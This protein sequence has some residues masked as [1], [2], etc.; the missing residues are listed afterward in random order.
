MYGAI[1]EKY[2]QLFSELYRA[3]SVLPKK[4]YDQMAEALMASHRRELTI[5][6]GH[7]ELETG[8]ALFEMKQKLRT[9]VPRKFLFYRNKVAKM[10]M[11]NCKKEFESYLSTFNLQESESDEDCTDLALVDTPCQSE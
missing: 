3:R 11:N 1:N 2:I 7:I 10:V 6:N 9:F 5:I 8:T 4:Q